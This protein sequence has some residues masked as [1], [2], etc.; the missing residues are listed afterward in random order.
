MACSGRRLAQ[1]PCVCQNDQQ[2]R[3]HWQWY[4]RMDY[5]YWND[6]QNVNKRSW[7]YGR[8]HG[9]NKARALSWSPRCSRCQGPTHTHTCIYTT[10]KIMFLKLLPVFLSASQE[11]RQYKVLVKDASENRK[12]DWVSKV[13]ECGDDSSSSSSEADQKPGKVRSYA[14]RYVGHF[15]LG[16][17]SLWAWL[18][19]SL[20]SVNPGS[21]NHPFWWKKWTHLGSPW[22]ILL[23]RA[24]HTNMDELNLDHGILVTWLTHPLHGL[25]LPSTSHAS[26]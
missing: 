15:F 22:S 7:S 23:M 13:M 5:S 4:E 26:P 16:S 1:D 6:D 12:E 3:S 20:I 2:H 8:Y 19:L 11:C 14:Y 25:V 10:I 17:A 24:G 9:N 18:F 21:I